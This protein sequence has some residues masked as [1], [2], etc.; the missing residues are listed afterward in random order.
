M[1]N[2]FQYAFMQRAFVVAAIIAVIAPCI[3]VSIVLKRLSAIGDATSHSALAGIAF[4]LLLG[5]NPILGAVMFSIFAVIGIEVFRKSFRVEN[6]WKRTIFRKSFGKYSEIATVVV[7]SAG[8]GLTAVLSGFIT[9]GSTNINSF[10]FGSIVAI[11]DFELYLTI[12]LGIAVIITSI[13]LYKELFFVT[14]DEE[15]AKLAGVPV[16]GINLVLMLL[17]AVTV[18]VASRIVGALMISSLLVIPVAAA[19][20]IAKSYKQ[21]IWWSI[22][23]AEFFTVAGLFISYYLDL[24]P[25]GTI[26]LLG[27]VFL[28]VIMV[29]TSKRRR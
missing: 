14:F 20:M 11:T 9:N 24:R 2:I 7:M 19:M 3:G 4:G 12:G 21:T 25:G 18:S 17:T 6:H 13:L 28:I 16:G 22:A 23:F 10:L 27:V 5:I 15:A 26:V 8:I 29:C 1:D